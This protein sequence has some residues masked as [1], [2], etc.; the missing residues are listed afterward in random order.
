MEE[1]MYTGNIIVFTTF[2]R[3]EDAEWLARLLV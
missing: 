1:R 3:R 2:E